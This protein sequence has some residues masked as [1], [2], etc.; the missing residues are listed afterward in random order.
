M[1]W[2]NVKFIKNK[3]YSNQGSL[4]IRW[5]CSQVGNKGIGYAE[6]SLRAS[7]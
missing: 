3:V 5:K 6:P 2:V 7:V 1:I 4:K